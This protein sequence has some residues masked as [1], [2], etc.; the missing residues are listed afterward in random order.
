VQEKLKTSVN[1][2]QELNANSV[3]W[4]TQNEDMLCYSGKGFLGI[5]A[6][7][8]STHQ[9]RLNGFVVGYCGSHIYCLHVHAMKSVDVPQSA[10]MY[11]YLER[12]MYRYHELVTNVS[13]S[14]VALFSVYEVYIFFVSDNV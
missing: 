8:F 6:G 12:D 11:Q 10:P 14:S 2:V 9:R 7:S 5:K 1:F 4:N 3:A 13:S